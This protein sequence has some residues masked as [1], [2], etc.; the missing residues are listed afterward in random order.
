MGTNHYTE[1]GRHVG[2]RSGL[3]GGRTVFLWALPPVELELERLILDSSG[4]WQSREAFRRLVAECA[5]QT[6]DFVGTTFS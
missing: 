2:K 5:E 1:S 6:E 4:G 3:G